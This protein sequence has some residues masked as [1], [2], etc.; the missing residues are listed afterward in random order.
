[1]D[2]GSIKDQQDARRKLY[3]EA[4][5]ALGLKGGGNMRLVRN[6]PFRHPLIPVAG[7]DKVDKAA[8]PKVMQVK[9]FG[10]RGGTKYTHLTAEDTTAF[11][12]YQ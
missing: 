11:D 4:T 5:G 3:D 9:N 6:R 10:R 1:M 2:E 12:D 8:L 7:A